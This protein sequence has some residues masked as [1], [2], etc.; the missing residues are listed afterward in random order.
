MAEIKIIILGVLQGVT[1]FLPISSSG[2]IVL[3]EH[4]LNI[5][6]DDIVIEVILHFGTLLSILVFFRKDIVIMTLLILLMVTLIPM[7]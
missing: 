1:E 7:I 6:K 3:F 2:H 4:F 5:A